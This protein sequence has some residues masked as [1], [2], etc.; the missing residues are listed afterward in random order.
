MKRILTALAAT[1]FLAAVAGPAV[2][3]CG[4]MHNQSVSMPPTS[5]E[6]VAQG[7]QSTPVPAQTATKEEKSE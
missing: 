6:Q 5:Q 4:A 7:E 3:E 2:A 1:G